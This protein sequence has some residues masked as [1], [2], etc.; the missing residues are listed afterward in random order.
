MKNKIKVGITGQS[1]LIGTNLCNAL[2]VYPNKYECI[3]FE[4]YYFDSGS[5]LSDFV[6]QCDIIVHLASVMRHNDD[7]KLYK[8]NICL[9]EKL[10]AA[11]VRE[12]A[13]PY[14]I[15][16]SSIQEDLDN[17]YGKSKLDG[18]NLFCK[19]AEENNASFTDMIIPNVFGPFGRPSYNS[20]ISTFC[21]KLTHNEKPQILVD[22][23][24]NLI[25]TGTL[26]KYIIKD[27]E[28]VSGGDIQIIRKERVPSDFSKNVSEILELLLKFKKQYFDDGIMPSLSDRNEFNLFTTFCSYIELENY[29]PKKLNEKSDER[30]VFVETIKMG[31]GGGQK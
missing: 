20:F 10:I 2:R 4:R 1:G 25:Y 12:N 5:L 17:A 18:F 31:G 7:K 3:P 9:V 13:K 28:T 26:C 15:Y 21:Y 27:I 29:F 14:L 22:N 24:V 8:I 23:K 11:L 19:W 16:A 30:G 6:K